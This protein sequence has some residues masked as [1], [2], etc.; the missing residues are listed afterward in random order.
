MKGNGKRSL[1]N[2]IIKQNVNRS[3]I[4]LICLAL[5]IVGVGYSFLVYV[6]SYSPI[7]LLYD[8]IG[9][10]VGV[11][12]A[13]VFFDIINEKLT[14]DSYAEE[15]SRKIMETLMGNPEALD[16][17]DMEQRRNFIQNTIV[18]MVGDKAVAE[19]VYSQMAEYLVDNPAYKI[20]TEFDYDFLLSGKLPKSFAQSWDRDKYYYVQERLTYKIRYLSGC[21]R[22]LVAEDIRIG[23]VFNN[24]SLD[25]ALRDNQKEVDFRNCVFRECL[26]VDPKDIEFFRGIT[27]PQERIEK[28]QEIFKLDFHVDNQRGEIHNV[29]IADNGIVVS[30][31]AKIDDVDEH[32]LRIVFYMPKR[33]G[34]L[35]EVAFMDPTKGPKISVTY[36]E[37]MMDVDMFSFL[38]KGEESSYEVAQEH[39]NG[40]YNITLDKEWIYPVSGMI[41]NVVKLEE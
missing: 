18:S 24:K 21:A 7:D 28:F 23:F 12:V 35:L 6:H 13:F 9:N 2:K 37:S 31:R 19:M 11:L 1:D 10:L 26:D 29:C 27:E 39:I 15:M 16:S 30:V 32:Q 36:D 33:W 25:S 8:V 20:R 22:N 5:L 3:Y 14:R 40:N 38:S 4:I 34:S 41:F 17:F